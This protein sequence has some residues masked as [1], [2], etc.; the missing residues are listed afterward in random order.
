MKNNEKHSKATRSYHHGNLR[1]TLVDSFIELLNQLPREKISMRKLASSIGVAPAAV[2]NHFSNRDELEIA[3]KIKC[4]NH[5]ADYLNQADMSHS[6]PKVRIKNLGV[7]YFKYSRDHAQ[8]FNLIMDN[9]NKDIPNNEALAEAGLRSEEA[10]RRCIIYLLE[11]ESLPANKNI[12]AL[13]SFACW[14]VS[15]GISSLVSKH[16]NTAACAADRWPPAFM[17]MTDEH[18]DTCFSAMASILVEGIIDMAKRE[19]DLS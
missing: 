12:E 10:L 8:Y 16:V 19:I 18:I 3:V 5:F 14:S 11:S 1:Q 2:Y 6:D 15:H 7:A 17:M 13:G 4:L 9:P